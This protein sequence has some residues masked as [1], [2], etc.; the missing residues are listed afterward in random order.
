[1]L[2]VCDPSFSFLRGNRE[3]LIKEKRIRIGMKVLCPLRAGLPGKAVA[4]AA[5]AAAADPRGRG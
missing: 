4:A 3:E 5:A 2:H 1:M